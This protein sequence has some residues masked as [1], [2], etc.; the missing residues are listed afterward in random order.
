[1]LFIEAIYSD[2]NYVVNRFGKELPGIDIFVCTAD[3]LIEPPSMVMNTVLS[4]MAYDYPPDKLS[5]YLSDDGGSDLTFYAM[6]EAATFSK[7]WLPFCKIFKV[8]P[9]SPEAYFR[10]ALEP[11]NDDPVMVKEWLSV[12]VILIGSLSYINLAIQCLLLICRFMQL[13]MHCLIQIGLLQM[14]Y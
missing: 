11:V 4:V 1:M 10:T 12:K 3:P 14:F 5:I 6:L 13:L 8:E 2:S 7:K 9:R